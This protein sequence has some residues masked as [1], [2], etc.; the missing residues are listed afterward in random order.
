MEPPGR[1]L[2][3]F[4][5]TEFRL[6][7]FKPEEYKALKMRIMREALL[8]NMLYLGRPSNIGR[9]LEWSANEKGSDLVKKGN[10][11]LEMVPVSRDAAILECVGLISDKKCM[12]VCDGN[13]KEAT[14]RCIVVQTC[15]VSAAD[16]EVFANDFGNV[17][18]NIADILDRAT[19]INAGGLRD[20]ILMY[21]EHGERCLR[22]EHVLFHCV[23][24]F[25]CLLSLVDVYC[26][27]VLRLVAAL[28]SLPLRGTT[29][30]AS[31]NRHLNMKRGRSSVG[32]V[33]SKSVA[34]TRSTCMET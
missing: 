15:T 28:Q 18:C 1:H 24:G 12:L 13:R 6:P 16:H 25:V 14:S 8:S 7:P 30:T 23:S 22:F 11:D 4:S 33:V 32:T 19:C 34:S 9:D 10:E 17:V 21:N 29:T 5:T 31:G 2:S 27:R 3:M 26:Y 20:G